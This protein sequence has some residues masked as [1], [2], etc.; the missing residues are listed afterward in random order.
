MC[1]DNLDKVFLVE[2]Q[3]RQKMIIITDYVL[4]MSCKKRI[5]EGMPIEK[6]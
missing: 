6:T 5:E 3:R 2:G 1:N 4:A